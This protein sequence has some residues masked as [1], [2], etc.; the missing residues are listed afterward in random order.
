MISSEIRKENTPDWGFFEFVMKPVKK[1][2]LFKNITD[3]KDE[4]KTINIHGYI[5]FPMK[6]GY[7]RSFFENN[8]DETGQEFFKSQKEWHS[9]YISKTWGAEIFSVFKD[10]FFVLRS[11]YYEDVRGEKS[12]HSGK[13]ILAFEDVIHFV[14]KSLMLGKQFYSGKLSGSE[15]VY[16]R[17]ILTKTKDR[18]LVPPKRDGWR[19]SDS[20]ECKSPDVTVEKV[21]KY[22]E[23]DDYIELSKI[24]LDEIFLCFNWERGKYL[25]DKFNKDFIG[26]FN[27]D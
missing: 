15:E 10:G 23:L 17:W 3:I 18:L 9:R 4:F 12:E 22:S 2:E 19:I 24:V 11:S 25:V 21:Y 13:P 8:N 5:P 7:K 20:P 27:E 6:G 14:T 1:K 26:Y 16:F